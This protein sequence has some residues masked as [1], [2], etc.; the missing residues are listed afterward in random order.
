MHGL[1]VRSIQ[2]GARDAA[3]LPIM[4]A[5]A[6]RLG[7]VPAA[8]LSYLAGVRPKRVAGETIANAIDQIFEQRNRPGIRSGWVV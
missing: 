2:R 7:P 3:A 8:T 4:A 1:R 6:R 5:T